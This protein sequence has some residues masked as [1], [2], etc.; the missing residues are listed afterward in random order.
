MLESYNSLI[1]VIDFF[2]KK[3]FEQYNSI[4]SIIPIHRMLCNK[5]NIFFILVWENNKNNSQK[6]IIEL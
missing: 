5:N 4:F 2:K 3:G 1:L 6:I